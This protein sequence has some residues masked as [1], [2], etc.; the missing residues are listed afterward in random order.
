[1]CLKILGLRNAESTSTGNID[2][3]KLKNRLHRINC[4]YL[5]NTFIAS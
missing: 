1:M 4:L 3:T 5:N 2:V